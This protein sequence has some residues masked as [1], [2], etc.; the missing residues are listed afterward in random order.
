MWWVILFPVCELL[1]TVEGHLTKCFYLH[2]KFGSLVGA[3]VPNLDR[4]FSEFSYKQ[5]HY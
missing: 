3:L 5:D 2:K 4:S 1:Y